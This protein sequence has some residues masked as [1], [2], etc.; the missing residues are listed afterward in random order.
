MSI[1]WGMGQVRIW[2]LIAI[3]P[4]LLIDHITHKPIDRIVACAYEVASNL[5]TTDG[6]EIVK[7]GGV[8]IGVTFPTYG[9]SGPQP[10]FVDQARFFDLSSAPPGCRSPAGK[11]SR[12]TASA[13]V[14]RRRHRRKPV[15][16]HPRS[17]GCPTPWI[18]RSTRRW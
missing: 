14:A 4:A 12:V 17:L 13:I 11:C 16:G 9:L 10:G 3:K 18:A 8:S 15:R 6:G 1:G 7:S 2:F 5:R